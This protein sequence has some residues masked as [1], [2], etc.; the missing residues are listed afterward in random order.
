MINTLRSLPRAKK[1]IAAAA[2]AVVAALAAV[3]SVVIAQTPICR[4]RGNITICASELIE[5][6]N[7]G[8]SLNDN[9]TIAPKGQPATLT[10]GAVPN[11]FGGV[12]MPADNLRAR[13]A[14]IPDGA[15]VHGATDIVIGDVKMVGDPSNA[16]LLGTR[17]K[18]VNASL[19]VLGRF[20]VDVTNRKIKIPQTS[21]V[22]FFV[23]NGVKRE[24]VFH[25]T[26]MLGRGGIVLFYNTAP[27][28][29]DLAPIE[30]EFDIPGKK[31]N[32]IF[33][34]PLKLDGA[35]KSDNAEFPN[36]IITARVTH[37]ANGTTTGAIDGFK[38]K[39]AGI[40]LS[41]SGITLQPGIFEAAQVAALKADN[42]S[43]PALT[44]DPAVLF[45]F[46]KLKYQNG[47]WS[48]GG[49][50]VPINNWEF[51]EAFRMINQTLSIQK[52]P[53]NSGMFFQANS[54]L[55][56]GGTGSNGTQVPAI[57]KVSSAVVNGVKT[58][59]FEAGLSNFNPSIGPL[60]LL[61]KNVT[62]AGGL[63]ENFYGLKAQTF[64]LQWPANLGGQT[65]AGLQ[66]FRMG[67]DKDKKLVMS[68]GGVNFG[69]PVM[70]SSVMK[71][72][73]TGTAGAVNNTPT[74]SMTGNMTLKLAGNANVGA[75]ASF[76]VRTGKNICA[77]GVQPSSTPK[78]VAGQPANNCV[79]RTDGTLNGFNFKIAGFTAGVTTAK[80]NE[81][82]G[83]SA[84]TISLGLP[85][86][87]GGVGV[88]VNGF[89]IAG[90]GNVNVTGGGFDLG[91][92]NIGNFQ[93]GGVRGTFVKD[94]VTGY[95]FQAGAKFP[96]P[97]IE[98][99]TNSPGISA[100]VTVRVNPANNTVGGGVVVS[101][102]AP[103]GV[104]IP[105]GNTGMEM[106]GISGGFDINAGTVQ[107]IA[108]MKANTLLR[109]PAP[110][111]LPIA[112]V[113][114]QTT[115][116][117]NPFRLT[118]NAQ[119]SILVFQVANANMGIGH[120]VA[121]N[122]T[123]PGFHLEVNITGFVVSGG[124][125]L[126]VGRVTV[127]G[128][129]KTKVFAEGRVTVGVRKG[130]ILGLPLVDRTF[131]SV[132]V[133]GGHF[134]DNRSG[135]NGK[136]RVGVKGTVNLGPFSATG[137]ADLGTNPPSLIAS[138]VNQI[139]PFGSAA[140]R[141][142]AVAGVEGFG[143]RTLTLSEAA[144]LGLISSDRLSIR[145]VNGLT[146][147]DGQMIL[148]DSVPFVVTQTQRLSAF[149]QFPAGN[150]TLR[151]VVPL[152]RNTGVLTLTKETV[153]GTTQRYGRDEGDGQVAEG[154]EIDDAGPGT[155]QLIID[156]AP[157]G[158][159]AKFVSFNQA[160]KLTVTGLTCSG[161][162][163][164][165]VTT[166]CNGAGTG[167]TAQISWTSSDIDSP[168]YQIRVGYAAITDAN[169]PIDYT[170]IKTLAE[171]PGGN[172]NYS[173]NLT[174]VPT[175]KYKLV[176]TAEDT[177]S[178]PVW[179]SAP[180]AIDIIDA[181][182]PAVPTGFAP[183]AQAG[184][185]L[186]KWNQNTEADLAGY[187]IGF[188]VVDDGR[189]DTALNFVYQRNMGPKEVVTGTNDIVD[190]KL[191]GL[192]D[193]QE[194]YYSIRAYDETGNRSDWAPMQIS[195]PWAL[196]PNNWFPLPNG[197]N[198]PVPFVEVGF[199]SPLNAGTLGGALTLIGPDDQPVE[200]RFEQL[201][202]FDETQIYGLRFVP[203]APLSA[204]TGYRAV[205]KGG[206]AGLAAVDGRT[207][208]GDY[209]WSFKTGAAAPAEGFKVL[210]PLASR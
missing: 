183:I 114:G 163:V 188:G 137:F 185:L 88:A 90:D 67:V 21:Q 147:N 130:Q 208:G 17:Y 76:I 187:E 55:E 166:N 109:V 178:A 139:V 136:E 116:Q 96:L 199:S 47:S 54:T 1:K 126:D 37:N 182:P 82:G 13:Y 108:G 65:A 115:L 193:N 74:I 209:V 42:L 160:P 38:A 30:A 131:A 7:G 124:I 169:L 98:P 122:N 49:A 143:S 23:Q 180:Q 99:G 15:A 155:Y 56:F 100:L 201:L 25:Y 44:A 102:T 78:G 206:D 146:P 53:D 92:F 152:P 84:Q 70:E 2:A 158:Y 110:I 161:P 196:G 39:I 85:Q 157:V 9:V 106:T 174:E 119:L 48:I 120:N 50:S 171:M 41:L 43:T 113:Q 179:K 112:T 117:F 162:A 19:S 69:L 32:A 184:E 141:A 135:Q 101:F 159:E 192:E 173:W 24:E 205:L 172:G 128:Q 177:S 77:P 154:F 40:V 93:F 97:G 118:A 95:V 107:I 52:K 31:M 195:R 121:F 168:D 6:E 33:P 207:M 111:N 149:I 148:Q 127:N 28:N 26:N 45:S 151:L 140:I 51:G 181:R 123:A 3:T 36:L 129:L 133:Q 125:K 204:F 80:L 57:V 191:W 132:N 156:N 79:K 197:E 46:T 34:I 81:D 210:L 59:S 64:D 5:L 198:E 138:D 176:V 8:F 61:L 27:V 83:F 200:G 60:K 14:F 165:G 63:A 71:I 203:K 89:S 194:M 91:N 186:V 145:G 103:F 189:P 62:F 68:L 18:Q 29:S 142:S 164:A 134:K 20:H 87:L 66:N 58:P 170:S 73:L 202:S 167:S 94:P 75:T 153:N 22:P 105:I 72:T 12:T 104:G 86:G 150:P 144:D 35:A 175:G 190:A 16:P 10:V 4:D 11:G